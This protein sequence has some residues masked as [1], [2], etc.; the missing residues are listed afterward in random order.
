MNQTIDIQKA[1]PSDASILTGI[2]IKS[3]HSDIH[4]GF[5]KEGGPPGYDSES[6]QL[7]VIEN[8]DYYKVL[9]G[10]KIIGGVIVFYEGNGKYN[11]ARIYIDP[12]YH[13]QGYGLL[14]MEMILKK[15]PDAKEWWLDT[16][17]VNTRTRP[18]YL[19]CGFEISREEG[20]LLI[21]KR[22]LQQKDE[23]DH[24][25]RHGDRGV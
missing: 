24:N 9:L 21:F 6:Y 25:H 14:A 11:L 17:S 4:H 5:D 22:V 12:D 2:S 10:Q 20:G 3:F 13:R 8:I 16:P 18:F 7:Q 19:K 15:Y 23:T 1:L